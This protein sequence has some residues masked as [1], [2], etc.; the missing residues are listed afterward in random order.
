MVQNVPMIPGF[1]ETNNTGPQPTLTPAAE[2]SSRKSFLSMESSTFRCPSPFQ[3]DPRYD[4]TEETYLPFRL[5]A[6]RKAGPTGNHCAFCDTRINCGDVG[7]IVSSYHTPGSY[8]RNHGEAN[9]YNEGGQVPELIHPTCAFHFGV[10]STSG[11]DAFCRGCGTSTK[12]G[13]R[14]YTVMGKK[15]ARCTASTTGKAYYCFACMGS[16]IQKNAGLLRGQI[17]MDSQCAAVAWERPR[18]FGASNRPLPTPDNRKI[19]KA[20]L[21]LFRF[22]D[23]DAQANEILA[24]G[25]HRQQQ[26]IIADALKEDEELRKRTLMQEGED[27]EEKIAQGNDRKRKKRDSG[28]KIN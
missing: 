8:S 13:E 19:K 23:V 11:K 4:M 20:Y 10:F 7:V 24:L 1:M 6:T 14:C 27:K 22:N 3:L 16:F 5:I 25:R 26:A 15:K 17:G 21:D 9:G 12:P 2:D 28:H 18:M